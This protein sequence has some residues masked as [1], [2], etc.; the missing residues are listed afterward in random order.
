MRIIGLTGGTGSGK[1]LVSS[2]LEEKGAYIV[3]CDK[4]AHEIIKKGECAYLELVNF[5]GIGILDEN[6][7]IMRKKLGDIVFSDES[8]RAFLNQCTHRYVGIRVNEQIEQAKEKGYAVLVIDAPLLLESDIR[9]TCNEIWGVYSD[10]ETRIKRIMARDDISEE[11]ARSRIAAQK[12]WDKI[13][14]AA[15]V[16]IYNNGD[17]SETKKQVEH[18]L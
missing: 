9:Y 11:Y 8:K 18:Y 10:E 4:I 12:E 2:F 16:V 13:K 7:E 3:D 5:F 17:I 14:E 15:D 6:G 1:G